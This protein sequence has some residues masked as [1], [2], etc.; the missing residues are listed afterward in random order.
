MGIF[1]KRSIEVKLSEIIKT[2]KKEI[3]SLKDS[4]KYHSFDIP[5]LVSDREDYFIKTTSALNN[6]NTDNKITAILNN[7]ETSVVYCEFEK[8]FSVDWH[9]HDEIETII[10]I[11]GSMRVKIKGSGEFLYDAGKTVKINKKIDHRVCVDDCCKCIV[12]WQ[13]K[14]TT[15]S[16]GRQIIREK[17][18][19]HLEKND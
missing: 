5:M 3:D 11:E 4:I 1:N 2:Q 19:D 14:F 13:P 15:N 7:L 16:S 9:H 8:G 10:I 17:L 6:N 18:I 12:M